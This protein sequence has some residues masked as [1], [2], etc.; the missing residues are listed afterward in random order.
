MFKKYYFKYEGKDK[1]MHNIKINKNPS[2]ICGEKW[3]RVRR[4]DTS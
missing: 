3:E 1:F 2:Q 4:N